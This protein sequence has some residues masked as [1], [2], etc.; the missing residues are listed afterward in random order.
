MKKF[1]KREIVKNVSSNWFALGLNV[2]VGVFLSPYV[3]H[4]LGDEAFGLW[5]LIFS[6]TGYYGLFDLGIRS[7]IVRYVA[8]YWATGD[9]EEMNRLI[10]TAIFSYGT[11]GIGAFLLT[12]IGSFYVEF[13]FHI[14]GAVLS[15]ARLLLLLVGG[16]IS[17][18]FPLGVFGGILEGLQ[19]F[20][21]LNLTSVVSTLLRALLIVF[22]LRH[23]G[24]LLTIAF[25]TVSL[26]LVVA[27]VNGGII[28][29]LLPLSFSPKNVDRASLRR[30]ASY[31]GTT[32]MIMVAARMRFKSD[33]LVIGTFLS[34]A[35]I[36]YFTVGSRL[37]EYAGEVVGCLA[38]IFAPMSSQAVATGDV[39]R[40][41]RIL[42]LGNRA[43]A[44]I[45]F[46]IAAT[47]LIIGKSVIE[48]WVGRRYVATG[49]P[50]LVVLLI[51]YTLLLAQSAS[52]RT[53]FGMARHQPLAYVALMEGTANL[54]LSILLVRRFG[55]LGDA[56]GT[57][58]PL[59]CTTLWFL[60]RHLCRIL[61][62]RVQTYLRQAFLLPLALAMPL[63]ATLLLLRHWFIAHNY[64][65]LAMQIA[66][67]SVVYAL[68]LLWAIKTQKA[69]HLEG[70]HEVDTARQSAVE[71]T[72]T[73]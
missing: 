8:K 54:I 40:L 41:R 2:L 20:Y 19:R 21:L 68:G 58:I 45:I 73:V 11:I 18:G 47:L 62:L 27:V 3:L 30:I 48:V 63:V 52:G 65:H 16:A 43:C 23:G 46:P 60:P 10:N 36:T 53:L 71:I 31:S 39:Q 42:V 35:A 69:L 13:I 50:V 9:V 55:V 32:F 25:V 57:A 24:G 7:S 5:V 22:T 15:T 44:L 56:V 66:L 61:N 72:E 64:F 17:V 37:V 59:A 29:H 33:A 38:Q 14:S 51:P 28:L 12:V 70:I 26:P 67:G 4:H 49:Y 6:I 1:N 34:S